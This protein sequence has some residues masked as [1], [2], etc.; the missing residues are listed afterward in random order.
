MNRNEVLT[1]TFDKLTPVR[2]CLAA[3]LSSFIR[4]VLIYFMYF[5]YN[6]RFHSF[7]FYEKTFCRLELYDS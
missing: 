3:S 5:M 6:D 1:N 2:I 7:L 4:F